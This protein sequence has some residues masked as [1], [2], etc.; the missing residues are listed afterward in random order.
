MPERLIRLQISKKRMIIIKIHLEETELQMIKMLS[1]M[2]S[3][4]YRM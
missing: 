1:W 2:Q 4:E 3:L